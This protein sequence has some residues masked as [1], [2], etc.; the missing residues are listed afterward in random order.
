MMP[1]TSHK[2]PCVSGLRRCGYE[3]DQTYVC[4]RCERTHCYCFGAAD[5]TPAIC[6]DCAA[7]LQP[8][9]EMT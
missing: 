5:D 4:P 2:K 1:H 8:L 7:L 3:P 6:D 9:W